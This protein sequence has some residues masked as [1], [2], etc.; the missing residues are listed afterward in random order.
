[1]IM[2]MWVVTP[3]LANSG[4]DVAEPNDSDLTPVALP[5]QEIPSII[6][7]RP[8][9]TASTATVL[10]GSI[11][12]ENGV[13]WQDDRDGSRTLTLPETVL[14]LGLTDSSEVQFFVPNFIQLRGNQSV[15]N[16]G[17]MRVGFKQ[18]L[19]TLPGGIDA[20]VYPVLTLPTGANSAT[21]NGVDP[22]FNVLMSR[23][24]KKKFSLASQLGVIVNPAGND[25]A[26]VI[27]NP[28]LMAGYS[29]KPNWGVYVEYASFNP[30]KGASSHMVDWG[31]NYIVGKRHQFDVRMGTGFTNVSP[32]LF[33][34]AG[35]AFRVDGLF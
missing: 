19:P 26:R 22:A 29:I 23:T 30:T 24:F 8:S 13:T 28:T 33:V 10:K 2:L 20:T 16:F 11:Q 21:G 18:T 14:R 4:L 32:S 1:M 7:D 15:S 3:V 9:F 35:Y 5:E 31:S 27:M 17:D 34:G 6:T 25:T 12:I